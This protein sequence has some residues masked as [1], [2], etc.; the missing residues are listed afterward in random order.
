MKKRYYKKVNIS[1]NKKEDKKLNLGFGV[2]TGLISLFVSMVFSSNLWFVILKYLNRTD[3]NLTD[4]IF[5]KDLSFYI[6]SLP[7]FKAIAGVL[8][9]IFITLIMSTF[10][11]YMA[12][13]VFRRPKQETFDREN[14]FNINGKNVK[15][16][17]NIFNKNIFQTVMANIG[18]LGFILFIVI[19]LNYFLNTYELLYSPRGVAYGASYADVNIT[20]WMYRAMAIV[21]LVSAPWFLYKMIKEDVKGA[22]IGPVILFS[23]IIIGNISGTVVQ[24]F[25]V[26]PDE[27]SKE[28]KYLEYNIEYTQKAYGLDEVEIDQ[29]PVDQE[30]TRED[31]LKNEDTVN[32][33]RIND[34]RPL[35][36]VYNQL[37]AIRL[38]YSFN[39]VDV[40][41]Y[42]LDDKYTQVFLSARELDQRNLQTKTWVNKYLK[43][44]HGYG[45]VVSPVNEVTSDGQP[46]FLV[47]NIPPESHP[48]LEITRPQIYFGE[49]P[50]E[51]IITNTNEKEFD[52]P[53]GSN[54]KET[55]YE[56]D[57]GIELSGLKK[58]LFAIKHKSFKM[59]ISN[60]INSDSRIIMH[61]NINDRIK[62]IAPFIEYD[63]NPYIVVNQ[64]DGNLYWIIDGYTISDKYPYSV[65]FT[66][67][68]NINYI[69]NSV[70]VVVDAYDG[71]T[72][73]YIFDDTDPI[74]KT[75]EKI[76]PDLF[77]DKSEMPKGLMAQTR[78]PHTLFNIQAEIY[79]TY[80]VDNPMVFY[81]EEDLWDI[82]QEKYM[83]KVGYVEPIYQMFRLPGEEDIEFLLTVSYTPKTKPNM[84]SLF[85]ARND[86]DEYG[87]LYIYKFPKGK[88]VD[89]PMM[90][91]SRI[92]QNTDISEQLTLWSQK[93]SA[94]LRGNV[95][96][97]PI[98]NSL[99]FIEP[100]YLQADN[101]NSLPEMKRVIVSF[102]DQL[103]MERTLDEALEKIFKLS[104]N[105]EDEEII[106]HEKP[107]VEDQEPEENIDTEVDQDLQAMEVNELIE[108]ANI[109]FEDSKAASQSGAW[110]DY[111]KYMDELERVLNALNKLSLE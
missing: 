6:F 31:I 107:P 77:L 33:I 44:T 34:Y 95:I 14:I 101:E 61:R 25:V 106:D 10:I 89:G 56:G 1:K 17:K 72:K 65:P 83:D 63:K 64:D 52:F 99:L 82:A 87:K 5:G 23:I 8:I 32:N 16:I 70:K 100:I 91:E 2:L 11:F 41:R 13:L 39:S 90:I 4:P 71:T 55:I 97:V 20:L 22:L 74:I 80:H 21:S 76:F 84:T 15:N 104:E 94:V 35:T 110:A 62:K 105:L 92:D 50:N 79:K 78:Y 49:T 109:L 75:Y 29:F 93:G 73:F 18:I 108:K 54:N 42:I 48:D 7:L 57:A 28:K 19:G 98:E 43:Y 27:I 66:S 67:D 9:L 68:S 88:T 111:G 45:M 81:N 60:N 24:K 69:R 46:K 30:L 3:F 12:M 86:G 102:K 40:G 96:T 36:Q 47:K 103:V 37:Q 51:Y 85:V 38:Y 53:E 26:E 59:L 58:I